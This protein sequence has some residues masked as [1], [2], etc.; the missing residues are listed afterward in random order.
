MTIKR[1][2]IFFIACLLGIVFFFPIV[3]GNVL[4]CCD[5]LLINI[6]ARVFLF[7]ELSHNRFPLWNPYIFSGTSFVSD[8]NVSPFYPLL[9]IEFFVSK[10][11]SMY[12]V[13]SLSVVF[14]I[15]FSFIGM[16]WCMRTL[17]VSVF[18][19][20]ASAI[21]FSYSGTVITY[22]NNIPML[23]VIA[24]LPWAVG[25]LFSYINKR[26]I[27]SSIILISVLS[28]QILAGH[29]QLT[30][31][32]WLL[33]ITI[34][35][36]FYEHTIRKKILFI[37][38]LSASV[39]CITAFQLFPFAESIFHSTR[40]GSVDS[41]SGSL[42]LSAIIRFVL[43]SITGDVR[44]GTDWWQGGAVIG[45]VGVFAFI[46]ALLGATKSK[47][48]IFFSAVALITLLTA[49]GTNT[50]VFQLA[51]VIIPGVSLFRV[52]AHFLLLYTFSIAIVAGYGVTSLMKEGITVRRGS[53]LFI[54][55]C[56]LILFY[57]FRSTVVA[58]VI[59]S[60]SHIQK[61]QN[62]FEFLQINGLEQLFALVIVNLFVIIVLLSI[63]LLARKSL[64]PY[65]LCVALTVELFIYSRQAFITL[66][67]HVIQ[68]YEKSAQSTLLATQT[69]KRIFIHPSLYPAPY[70]KIFGVPAIPK[71]I[72][73]QYQILRPNIATLWN[74][75]YIDGYGSIINKNYQKYF[76][77][78]PIDPTGVHITNNNIE[79]MKLLLVD[80]VLLPRNRACNPSCIMLESLPTIA[81]TEH[82]TV[83]QLQANA[84]YATIGTNG[85]TKELVPKIRIPGYIE[86]DYAGDTPGIL[87]LS[88][89]N[90][91]GWRVY[92]NGMKNSLIDSPLLSVMLPNGV[93]NVTFRY[94]PLSFLIGICLSVFFITGSGLYVVIKTLLRYPKIIKRKKDGKY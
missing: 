41:G 14:H 30:Y 8:L 18:A 7:S 2:F 49:F 24:Y 16:Y 86:F 58:Y 73:W 5:N 81:E 1:M 92:I 55:L 54:S 88:E 84:L 75:S 63:F 62:K 82:V 28:L 79:Q 48:S 23:Q 25:A 26:T 43:P 64:K 29:P 91:P 37:L 89:T 50:P 35:A 4:Y 53:V 52:P 69:D 46:L 22:V 45:Y 6:P 15:L 93:S 59:L 77:N 94:L 11:V 34:V 67:Y 85:I 32:S 31:Y 39:F 42:P 57:F 80:R 74:T 65:I 44:N 36:V 56:C 12:H 3:K 10:I 13:V 9:L 72:E 51:R 70:K 27:F 19:S 38:F 90:A 66:P 61:F 76:G 21:I 83:K 87:T 20:L 68:T 33:Y 78:D 71:E 17:R 47:Y 60:F 40:L